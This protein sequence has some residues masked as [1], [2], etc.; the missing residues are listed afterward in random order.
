[1][2]AFSPPAYLAH[3]HIQTMLA[4]IGPR[5]VMVRRRSRTLRDTARPQVIDAGN[6]VRLYGVYN[7]ATDAAAAPLVILLHGWEGCSESSYLLSAGQALHE[8][9]FSIFRLNLRD[10]GDSHHLNEALFNSTRIEEVANAVDVVRQRFGNGRVLLA[11]FSL[12]GNFAIRIAAR[13]ANA[14]RELDKVAAICPLVS[15]PHTTLDIENGLWL[16]H[17][18]FMYRWKGSLAKKLALFPRYDYGHALRQ[19]RTLTELNAYFVPNHTDFGRPEDYLRAYAIDRQVLAD[20]AGSLHILAA[21]DDPIVRTDY[22]R[23]LGEVPGVSIDIES[24]GGHCGFIKDLRF[25]SYADDWLAKT[26]GA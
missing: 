25:A 11:G 5:R 12:G 24:H 17:A 21:A 23:E 26:L 2:P 18:Y 6:G 1:M 16:Y 4:S 15:P 13:A 8:R 7:P 20:A 22:L 3:H 19:S 9:G 10:H 14:G